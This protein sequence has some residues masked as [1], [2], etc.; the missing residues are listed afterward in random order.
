LQSILAHEESPPLAFISS[1]SQYKSNA[2]RIQTE[3]KMQE[4]TSKL[5]D[6]NDPKWFKS[7]AMF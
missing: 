2:D 7:P 5:I 3:R 4:L 1:L 6:S